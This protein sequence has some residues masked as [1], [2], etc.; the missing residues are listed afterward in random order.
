MNVI[1]IAGF[2][3]R[4]D[5]WSEVVPILEQAG[6]TVHTPTLAGLG[7]VD[8]DRSEVTLAS[9]TAEVVALVDALAADAADGAS[10]PAEKVVLVGHS[11]GGA[12]IHGVVDARPDRIERAVYVDSGPTPEGV[13]I[14]EGLEATDA[15][16]PLPPWE[17]FDET[18]L[19]DLTDEQLAWFRE[20][21]VPEPARVAHDQQHL[22]N[23]ARYEVPITLISSTFSRAEIE[24]AIA[25]GIP[26]FAEVPLMARSTI[27]GLP[28]G[29]WPQFTKPR[30]LAQLIVD[31]VGA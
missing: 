25:A 18:D 12:I 5:S 21:A 6:L 14:N 10:D 26:Y 23:P 19:R 7:S 30:E 16:A 31:A 24:E 17:D 11:G 2:W 28:T 9:Q 29:H 15:D 20:I 1:L 27:V 4:G 8:D 13:A 3:L 22:T